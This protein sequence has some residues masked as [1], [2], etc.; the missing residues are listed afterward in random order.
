MILLPKR[1]QLVMLSATVPNTMQF[2]E[3][4][5]RVRDTQIQVIS[6][7]KRPV[8]LEIH[9][10]TGTGRSKRD[11]LFRIMDANKNFIT[12]GML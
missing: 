5:G 3:W 7:V 2:A 12:G 8:P 4:L 11:Q 9:L 1:I 6:T 10:F